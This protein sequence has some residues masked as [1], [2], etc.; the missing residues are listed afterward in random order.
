M[1]KTKDNINKNY[2]KKI[3]LLQSYDKFYYDKDSPVVNDQQYDTLKKEI[4]TLEINNSFLK[5]YSRVND[6]VGYKPSSKFGK[7]K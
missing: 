5:K 7:I 2:L 4:I 3:K 6:S 1:S